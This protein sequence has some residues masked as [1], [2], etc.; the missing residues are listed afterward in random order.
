MQCT[1]RKFLCTLAV[2]SALIL[3]SPFS[4]LFAADD[5]DSWAF[6]VIPD[7]QWA[8]NMNAP[9]HGT[10]IHIIDAINAEF[11]RQN[12][13]FVIAVGDL[14]EKH[15][16]D[17]F[18]T[19]A[20]HNKVLAEAGIKFYPV[21]GNHDSGSIEAVAQF[22]SAFPNLPG[23]LGAGGSFPDLP[24]ASG[25]TYSFTHKGGK[26]VLLDTFLMDD[27]SSKG[28]TY[29]ISNYLPWIE[30]ELKK[31]DHHFALV[32]AHKN[33]QGQNHRDNIFGHE[34]DSNPEMQNTFIRCLQQN[35]V[36]FFLS[37]HDHMYHRLLI[38][39]PDGHSEVTQI[40][41]GSA[42]SKF[43]LPNLT[44]LKSLFRQG[45]PLAQE[46]NR[47]GFMIVR[48]EG[49]RIK[50]EYYSTASFGST[51]KTPV[52]ELRDSFEYI[53]EKLKSGT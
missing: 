14:V 4:P 45:K 25:M 19:R 44:F 3:L 27:G 38:K 36:K 1:R 20:A 50:F 10:A 51:A 32:F 13:D 29:T 23:T 39:S 5:T 31:S 53:M 41:C 2:T 34:H 7:T 46:L 8:K 52:W 37:G 17:A 12:V 43:Y 11:V 42:A 15:S 35:G 49:E 18:K 16:A 48:V 30:S 26:F 6:G 22:K 33:L 40:I 21:R 47:I 24:G 9:F 28:K